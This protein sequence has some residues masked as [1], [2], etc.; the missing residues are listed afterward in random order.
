[1]LYQS[2]SQVQQAGC[3]PRIK[4]PHISQLYG[5]SLVLVYAPKVYDSTQAILSI[6]CHI[7]QET[8]EIIRM[9]R[10]EFI[11]LT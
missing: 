7:I 3:P 10:I 1:M 8:L 9:E 11:V 5:Q 2:L 4:R 6:S